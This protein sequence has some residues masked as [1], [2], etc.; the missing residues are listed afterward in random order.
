VEGGT[1]ERG[2]VQV[3]RGT[4][5]AAGIS[6][7]PTGAGSGIVTH[8]GGLWDAGDMGASGRQEGLGDCGAR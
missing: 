2:G 7:R 5:Q 6:P 8:S 3:W 4:A 1:G